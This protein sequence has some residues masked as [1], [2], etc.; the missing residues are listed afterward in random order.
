[1]RASVK[2][3]L[4]VDDGKLIMQLKIV[5][6]Q[7]ELLPLAVEDTLVVELT[8]LVDG[9]QRA[10]DMR[11]QL[12]QVNNKGHDVFLPIFLGHK[13]IH[14]LCPVLDVLL[15]SHLRIIRIRSLPDGLVTECQSSHLVTGTAKNHIDYGAVLPLLQSFVRVF[16]ATTDEV[17]LHSCRDAVL[18]VNRLDDTALANLKVQMLAGH[19]IVSL[20]LCFFQ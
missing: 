6:A 19:V 3:V 4:L 13:L 17:C 20:T 1:M 10:V 15:T 11:V 7:S 2:T 8:R 9:H 18:F 16:D 14:I 12:I 5:V